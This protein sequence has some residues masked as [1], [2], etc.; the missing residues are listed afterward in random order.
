MDFLQHICHARNVVLAEPWEAF[1]VLD[2]LTLQSGVPDTAAPRTLEATAENR[3]KWRNALH[4]LI[5][6]PQDFNHYITI[7]IALKSKQIRGKCEVVLQIFDVFK[8]SEL[9][10]LLKN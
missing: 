10:H 9:T 8:G 7:H 1:Y 5:I 3:M 6:F 2:G 4:A